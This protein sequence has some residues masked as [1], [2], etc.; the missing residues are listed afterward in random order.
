G[1]YAQV[2]P[3]THQRKLHFKRGDVFSFDG[4]AI[5][6]EG[7]EP[8]PP[9]DYY[10]SS[11]AMHLGEQ[12][13]GRFDVLFPLDILD[14]SPPEPKK[15]A[16]EKAAGAETAIPNASSVL[17]VADDDEQAD[18]FVKSLTSIGLN[19]QNVTFQDNFHTMLREHS[20]AGVFLIMA[21][22][23]DHAFATAI[24]V[25]SEL[26]DDQPMIL[27][28]PQWTRSKVLKA[29]KYGACDIL[30]TPAETEDISEK[31]HRHMADALATVH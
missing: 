6:F 27:A 3:E 1:V 21:E 20:F 17:V 31:V 2:F 30:I 11:C 10:L 9:G 13:L 25:R 22:V 7:N 14:I 8:V 28:G 23:E 4:E 12:D 24:K 5:A 19:C 18:F 29:L 16:A 15:P 26:K